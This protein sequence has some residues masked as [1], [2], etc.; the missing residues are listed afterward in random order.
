MEQESKILHQDRLSQQYI[1]T[2]AVA[3][4]LWLCA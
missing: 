1:D 3:I 2:S 4:Q